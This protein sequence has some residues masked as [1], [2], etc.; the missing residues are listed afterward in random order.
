M[1][2]DSDSPP[3]QSSAPLARGSDRGAAEP[4]AYAALRLRV[5]AVLRAQ[6]TELGARWAFQSRGVTL[7]DADESAAA[8]ATATAAS[9]LDSLAEALASDGATSD[10]AVALGLAFGA[11]A[12][13][14]GASLHHALKSLE[15]LTAMALYS[16][17]SALS[18]P[19]AEGAGVADGVRL[20]RRLQQASSLVALSAA[21]GYTHAVGES[22]RDR[23]RLLRHDLR[24][25]LGTIKSALALMEDESLPVDARQSPRFRAMATRNARAL[26]SLIVSQLSDAAAMLP[27]LSHQQ[28]SLR[29]IACA[30]RRDL[31]AEADAR[32]V[33][34]LVSN[35][36]VEA[37]VDAAGLEL[38][39]H[40]LL[41]AALQEAEAGGE[42]CVEFGA[43]AKGRVSVRLAAVPPRPPVR[44]ESALRRAGALAARMGGVLEPGAP[45][46]LSVPVQG[47]APPP[48]QLPGGE[49]ARDATSNVVAETAAAGPRVGRSGGGG[50]AG[51][52]L[53]GA[54]ERE[55]GQPGAL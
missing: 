54:R 51:H 46:T 7:R 15:L 50:D 14:L 5:A 37:R 17:E 53:R 21:K 47:S 33:T 38:M 28:V 30:V 18:G 32:G 48:D 40:E 22:L 4:A 1:P 49:P 36:G 6:S 2:T 12:F 42:L 16:V 20:A 11:D 26:D 24:N 44:D 34:V 19:G 3:S 27:S 41:L 35:A 25:P 39:L 43:A 9:L 10:E 45:L 52:D 13:A 8:A 29:L 31:R 23:F 55:H